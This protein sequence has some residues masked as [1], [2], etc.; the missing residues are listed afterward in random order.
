MANYLAA[1]QMLIHDCDQ[2]M[3]R[4]EDDINSGMYIKGPG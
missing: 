2:L 1:Q 4:D 3:L